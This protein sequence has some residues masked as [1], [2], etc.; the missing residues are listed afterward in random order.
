MQCSTSWV[1]CLCRKNE[2]VPMKLTKDRFSVWEDKDDKDYQKEYDDELIIKVY[3]K[4]SSKDIADYILSLQ[5][6]LDILLIK[7]DEVR[8]ELGN[9]KEENMSLKAHCLANDVKIFEYKSTLDEIK[10]L[11][12]SKVIRFTGT[13]T[14]D[15]HEEHNDIINILVKILGDKQ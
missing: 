11:D 6:D 5:D 1:Q 10:K 4:E 3:P 13:I 14:G 2:E 8:E 15:Q 9:L 7:H 12:L